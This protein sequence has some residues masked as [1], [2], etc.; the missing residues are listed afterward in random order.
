M[1]PDFSAKELSREIKNINKIIIHCS[2]SDIHAHDDISVI[3]KW[4]LERGFNDVGYHF[5]VKKNGIV[6]TGRAIHMIGAHCVN[7]NLTSI[8]ICLSGK[9]NFT[10]TQFIH[11]RELCEALMDRYKIKESG[12]Y[13]HCYF[14]KNKTCPNFNLEK[15]SKYATVHCHFKFEKGIV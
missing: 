8:G 4:H 5:F 6:Q 14:S 15:L 7:Q 10:E 2:D 1:N 12:I 13:P 3:R 11:A 9:I